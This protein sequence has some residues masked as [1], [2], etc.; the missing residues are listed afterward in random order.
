MI[1]S[2]TGIKLNLK[3]KI[4]RIIDMEIEIC[5]N[6][7]R[8]AKIA[9]QSGIDRIELCQSLE[10]GGIT[11]S[12]G[13]IQ[14]SVGLKKEFD[15]KVCVLIRA[16][17]GDFCYSKEEYDVMAQDILFCKE[18]GVDDIVIGG[19][20]ENGNID[21]KNMEKLIGVANGMGLVFHRAFDLVEQPFEVL[22]EIIDLGFKRILTSGTKRTAFEGKSILQKLVKQAAGRIAIMPGSGI[23]Q[24]NVKEILE[25]TGAKDIHFSAKE[26]IESPFGKGEDL[27]GLDYSLTARSRIMEMKEKIGALKA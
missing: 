3:N 8:S 18:N 22:E 26:L 14:L 27:F 9:A 11:P 24:S 4:N 12:A 10:V 13:D 7:F 1:S 5:T 25:F 17:G 16:R 19:L 20:T 21:F 6:S 23:N 15:F 2:K